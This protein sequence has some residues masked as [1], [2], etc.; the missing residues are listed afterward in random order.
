MAWIKRN[1]FFVIGGVLALGLLGAASFYNFKSWRR[2]S[3]AIDRLNEIC[4]KLRDL[5]NQKPSPG[6]ERIDNIKAA[7]EQEAQLRD[8]VR[9]AGDDFQPIEPIPA[10]NLSD[11]TFAAVLRRTIDQMQHE[12]DAVPVALPPKYSF[13]F[14][15]ECGAQRQLVKFA[16]GSLEPLSRQ[17]GEVKAIS[18]VL[19]AA[20]VNSLDAIQRL[21]VSEDDTTGPQADYFDDRSVTN[22]LAVLAPYEITFH[23]FTPEIAEVLCGFA[24]SPHGFIIK[25][26]N[27]QPVGAA[28]MTSPEPTT[29]P[30]PPTGV[31][32][33]LPP[34]TPGRGGLQTV[35][36]EQLLRVTLVVE[37]VKLLPKR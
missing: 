23:S 10:S 35:L 32:M 8:W 9:G 17:L 13:S 21:R 27:V 6:S 14:E 3:A 36:T 5:N 2:N 18:E 25:G 20:R 15:A 19:F 7:R 24:S 4:R 33:G 1:L 12:A 16:A 30:P 31:P 28:L 11:E 26:I 22:D 34:A 29:P 37:V